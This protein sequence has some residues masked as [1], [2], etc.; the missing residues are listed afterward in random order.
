MIEINILRGWFQ[1][2]VKNV[3]VKWDKNAITYNL[4]LL[5]FIIQK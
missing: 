1:Y 4:F 2:T 5:I 3:Q